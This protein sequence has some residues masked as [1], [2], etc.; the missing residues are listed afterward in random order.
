MSPL[1]IIVFMKQRPKRT[2]LNLRQLCKCYFG[3]AIW[4]SD[5]ISK[6]LHK[7]RLDQQIQL[8]ELLAAFGNQVANFIQN[9]C[10]FALFFDGR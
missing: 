8:V 7:L 4:I 2:N 9:C 5:G 1:N 3:I 6:H 10:N